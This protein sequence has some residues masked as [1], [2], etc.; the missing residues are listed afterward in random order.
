[1]ITPTGGRRIARL[2][3]RDHDPWVHNPGQH[4]D[5]AGRDTE[6]GNAQMVAFPLTVM[7]L[8]AN[9]ARH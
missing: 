8:L 5:L 4:A 6:A 3:Y 9:D 1:M 7:T 2:D